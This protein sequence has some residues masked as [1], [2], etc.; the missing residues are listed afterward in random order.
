MKKETRQQKIE[1]I[2]REA[3]SDPSGRRLR[4]L[5]ERGKA[6]LEQRRRLDPDPR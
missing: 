4:E 2:R 5:Y 1:R 3:E 6:E